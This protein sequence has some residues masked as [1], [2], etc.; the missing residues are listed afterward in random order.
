MRY[1]IGRACVVSLSFLGG[2]MTRQEHEELLQMKSAFYAKELWGVDFNWPVILNGRLRKKL[3][4][5]A[6]AKDKTCWIEIN[7]AILPF[8]Y[9]TDNILLHELCH[10]WLWQSGKNW[11][12]RDV[13]FVLECRR[14]GSTTVYENYMSNKY[15]PSDELAKLV[16][17]FERSL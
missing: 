9:I 1:N 11:G 8:N 10:W 13:E 5:F 17:K 6:V 2:T 7:P 12:D 3:G 15:A 16:S 14:I 4:V